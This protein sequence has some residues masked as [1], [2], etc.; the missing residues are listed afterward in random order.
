MTQLM[1]LVETRTQGWSTADPKVAAY[2]PSA[3]SPADNELIYLREQLQL[4]HNRISGNP[5]VAAYQYPT[6][7]DNNS[8]RNNDELTRLREENRCLSACPAYSGLTDYG[9][10]KTLPL[11]FVDEKH[12]VGI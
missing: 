10:E 2:L 6:S 5:I 3:N 8:T 12:L 1:S 7:R 9:L 4:L 11:Y